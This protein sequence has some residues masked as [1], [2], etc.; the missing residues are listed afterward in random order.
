M[1]R[2]TITTDYSMIIDEIDVG[3]DWGLHKPIARAALL[4]E[5]I[6]AI[7]VARHHDELEKA[8]ETDD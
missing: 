4:N 7:K 6:A 8:E 5:I 2:I 1:A 3:L